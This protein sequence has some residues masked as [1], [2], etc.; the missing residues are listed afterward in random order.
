ME[1]ALYALVEEG[2]EVGQGLLA[3]GEVRTWKGTEITLYALLA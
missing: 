2:L 1:M 3:R